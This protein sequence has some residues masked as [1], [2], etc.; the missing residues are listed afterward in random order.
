MSVNYVSTPEVNFPP[1][2]GASEDG[3]LEL[4]IYILTYAGFTKQNQF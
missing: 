4:V 1:V 2:L 3:V